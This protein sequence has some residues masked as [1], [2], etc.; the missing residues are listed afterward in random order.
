MLPTL[1]ELKTGKICWAMTTCQT[2]QAY[3]TCGR[4]DLLMT[5]VGNNRDLAEAVGELA[6]FSSGAGEALG[7]L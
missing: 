6:A 2:T 1:A 3:S 7:F 4:V 5:P